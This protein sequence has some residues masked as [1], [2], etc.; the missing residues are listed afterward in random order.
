MDAAV[1]A[2]PY[3][4][5]A[6]TYRLYVQYSYCLKQRETCFC[7]SRPPQKV[8]HFLS[9]FLPATAF[10]KYRLPIFIFVSFCYCGPC[11]MHCTHIALLA[12][13]HLAIRNDAKQP[14]DCL[15]GSRQWDDGTE[16]MNILTNQHE[17]QRRVHVPPLSPAI[18]PKTMSQVVKVRNV[19]GTPDDWAWFQ[20][21]EGG[22]GAR[23]GDFLLHYWK[24]SIN[25]HRYWICL[26]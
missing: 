4:R 16:V 20:D 2:I 21:E 3:S 10:A 15:I 7:V 9:C 14:W 19:G 11:L 22:R 1:A 26:H 17:R 8:V 12:T 23:L 5:T 6:D 24:D 18:T 13:R 25:L